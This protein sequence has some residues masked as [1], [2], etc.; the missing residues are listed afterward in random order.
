MEFVLFAE[1]KCNKVADI[2]L[3]V[4]PAF[5]FIITVFLSCFLDFSNVLPQKFYKDTS[6]MSKLTIYHI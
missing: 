3:S 1:D 6:A 2:W 4:W 5:K